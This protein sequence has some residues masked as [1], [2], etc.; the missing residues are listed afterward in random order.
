MSAEFYGGF[1]LIVS[2]CQC[3]F[4]LL[5]NLSVQSVC[6]KSSVRVKNTSSNC[7]ALFFQTPYVLMLPWHS[8]QPI[9]LL[10]TMKNLRQNCCEYF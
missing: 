2:V 8:R 10:G 9:A 6:S 3:N 1:K 4:L 7:H 5:F